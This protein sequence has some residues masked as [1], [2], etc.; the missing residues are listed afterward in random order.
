VIDWDRVRGLSADV[1]EDC[2]G[3]VMALFFDEAERGIDALERADTPARRAEALHFLKAT[4][5]NLGFTGLAG[6]CARR[7]AALAAGRAGRLRA[8]PFRARLAASRAAFAAGRAGMAA[9]PGQI[10]NCASTSSSVMSW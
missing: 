7:E 1:G 8:T 6:L 9:P 10:R 2:F 5:L 3:E 4:A